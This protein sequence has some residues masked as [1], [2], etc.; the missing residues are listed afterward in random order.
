MMVVVDLKRFR[1][2]KLTPEETE[3]SMKSDQVHK[4]RTQDTWL[5]SASADD[6]MPRYASL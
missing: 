2:L 4:A 6:Q 3:K 1:R 5:A